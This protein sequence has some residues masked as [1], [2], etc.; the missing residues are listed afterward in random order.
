MQPEIHFMHAHRFALARATTR[1][2]LQAVL[3]TI[4][5]AQI[6]MA[7]CGKERGNRQRK[8][9]G[10]SN[11]RFIRHTGSKHVQHNTTNGTPPH[12][13]KAAVGA[14]IPEVCI[15]FPLLIRRNMIKRIAAEHARYIRIA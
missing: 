1:P 2:G 8:N 15:N 7:A 11:N 3:Y 13:P 12:I 6:Q 10:N 14:A 4:I 5:K 9:N